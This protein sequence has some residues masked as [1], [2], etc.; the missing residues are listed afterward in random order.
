MKQ[1]L[2]RNLAIGFGF[3]LFILLGSSIASFLSIQNL[4]NSSQ[5]VNHTYEVITNLD[6]VVTPIREAETAQRGFLISGDPVYLEPFHGSFEESL[7]ALERV[8]TLTAD[9]PPQ[10]IR[11]DIL[12]DLV[13]KK[14]GKLEELIRAKQ[15]TNLIDTKQLL[16]GKKYTDSISSIV[17]EMKNAEKQ[18]LSGRTEKFEQFSRYTPFIIII[19]S[20]A[21]VLI[22][23][24]FYIRV[25]ND[26]NLRV[27]LQRDLEQKDLEISRRINTVKTIAESISAGDY[28]TRVNDDEKDNLG[29]LSAALNKMGSTLQYSFNALSEKEW[30]QTGSALIS[31]TIL[32]EQTV[33]QLTSRVLEVMAGYSQT[34]VGA[35]YINEGHETLSFSAGYAF[36]PEPAR[37]N[38]HFGEGLIGEAA[39]SQKEIFLQ[40]VSGSPLQISYASGSLK[41][42]SIYVIPISFEKNLKGVIELGSLQVYSDRDRQFFRNA[43]D[44]IAVA[45]NTAQNRARLQEVLE[46]VQAQSEELQVQHKEMELINAEMETQ[47]EKLQVSEEELKVQQEELMQTNRELEERSKLLEEKNELIG[48]RNREIQKKAEELAQSTRYKSEFLANMSHEL[49]TPLNS[50]LLLSRLMAENKDKTLS[51]DQVEYAQVIQ[52]SGN[53]LLELIDEILDLSKIE[54]GKMDL[55]YSSISLNTIVSDMRALFE[56]MAREKGLQLL[57]DVDSGNMPDI[58]TDRMRLE[59]ILKNLLSNALKFTDSGSISMRVKND[60]RQNGSFILFEIADSGIG[61]PEEK[62]SLIFEAFQQ[63]DGSTKRKYGGTGLGLSISRELSRL[64]N[65]ELT[66]KSVEGAGSTF[67]LS[68]PVRRMAKSEIHPDQ[69][70]AIIPVEPETHRY[71]HHNH[72]FTLADI[73]NGIPDDRYLISPGDKTI[74]IVEDDTHFASALLEFTRSRHY[75]G[76]VAVRGD[77]GIQ[78]AKTYQPMGILLDIQLPVRNG[79]EVM[80]ELKRDPATRHIPV[81]IMSS[82][83]AKKESITKGAVDFINKPVAFDQMSEIFGKIEAVLNQENS[84]VLIVEENPK[85]ARALS[86]YLGSFQ[87]QSSIVK[88]IPD[89]I[90]ALKKDEVNCVILDMGLPE[91]RSYDKL[92][93]IKSTP[94]FENI[95]IIIFTGK[96][97]SRTE[98]QRVRQYAD[99][100]VIK[101]AHSYQRILDEVSLFLHIMDQRQN[102]KTSGLE[103]LG[104]LDEVLKNKTVLLA[105]DDVRNI[106]SLTKILE[107]HKMRILPA[108]DGKEAVEKIQENP[109]V[110]IVLMDMMMPEMDGFESIRKIRQMPAYKNLPIIAITAKAMAG[111][112]EKCIEAGASD[113]ISKPVDIDQLIS[114]LRIWLYEK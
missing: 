21:A 111:D 109:Q 87:V 46:E 52:S 82:F 65:G 62:L 38:I 26:I 103:R 9:N 89:S 72:Q 81:H 74:L 66:V 105:D 56:P 84:K 1:S 51:K 86:Y 59:Q 29:S 75:R 42:L 69:P 28:S 104:S 8:K 20:L 50:I 83:E 43:A 106:F 90:S 12:R 102:N 114:L 73:P 16:S 107:Q 61:I 110:S 33:R 13:N 30:L 27:R 44:I 113:Y 24:F 78:L 36:V 93:V 57:F 5:W 58:E 49:R 53:G 18:L 91:M 63:A 31:E 88:S 34:A 3:S 95:P 80:D 6:A 79:W 94:G 97:F 7:A 67:T 39:L 68:I 99:S 4:L 41:P 23:L 85:H 35:V 70:K 40:E 2:T 60:P 112:R 17:G 98:E 10:Q 71:E 96:S 64:L 19:S 32:G 47:T 45:I 76:I 108:I 92:E 37:K 77:E 55:D 15:E 25:R 48:H 22:A 54:A 11:S 101:T 100:I 14:Y